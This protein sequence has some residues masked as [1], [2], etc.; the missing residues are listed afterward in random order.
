MLLPKCR[1]HSLTTVAH[2]LMA[3]KLVDNFKLNPDMKSHR[4]EIPSLQPVLGDPSDN[5]LQ[6]RER[7]IRYT[8]ST[9]LY[10]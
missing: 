6:P 10:D 7:P 2:S 1:Q 8:L 4:E 3:F 9:V 5:L